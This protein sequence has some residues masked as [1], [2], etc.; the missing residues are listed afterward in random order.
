MAIICFVCPVPNMIGLGG[1]TAIDS[2]IAGTTFSVAVPK[3][4]PDV[5][6]IV[7][8]PTATEVATPSVPGAL[9]MVATPCADEDHITWVVSS[10]VEASV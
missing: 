4:L 3:I 5:A 2:R 6:V 9:L 1:V 8:V 10:W 7:V